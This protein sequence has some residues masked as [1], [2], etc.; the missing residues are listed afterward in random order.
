MDR[1]RKYAERI[2]ED[3]FQQ[4][5]LGLLALTA[6]FLLAQ[7][8]QISR[9]TSSYMRGD[10]FRTPLYPIYLWAL[11][12]IFGSAAPTA[13]FV[14]QLLFGLAIVG[15]FVLF[16]RRLFDLPSWLLHVITVLLLLLPYWGPLRV[17]NQILT[18]GL[19]YPLFLLTAAHLIRAVVERNVRAFLLFCL[20]TTLSV[21]NR[22]Q[23][24]FLYPIGALAL[25]WM[26]VQRPSSQRR[27]ML[28]LSFAAVLVVSWLGDRTYHAVRHDAFVSVPFTGVQLFAG[29]LYIA[30]P[31]RAKHLQ[32]KDASFFDEVH[33]K[34]TEKHLLVA[35]SPFRTGFLDY[36]KHY[37][38][39]YS[40]LVWQVI[41]PS[42]RDRYFDGHALR[43]ADYVSADR[44]L[45]SMSIRLI[46]ADPK[47]FL[48]FYAANLL[49]GMGLPFALLTLFVLLIAIYRGGWHG[50]HQALAIAVVVLAHLANVALVALVEPLQQRYTFYTNTVLLALLVAYLARNATKDASSSCVESPAS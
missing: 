7:G 29:V 10:V 27:A 34:A 32:G 28:V 15:W 38:A 43:P 45:V 18:E 17:G 4:V 33:R 39:S 23:F 26:C 14:L 46:R 37:G 21:L 30:P 8:A 50:D 25:L 49:G 9:D 19:A 20:F 47:G 2:A 48:R 13:A 31:E 3:R 40:R 36:T 12:G 6:I 24:M 11:Q 1:L 35:D 5:L 42:V 22:P 44:I 41:L 16:V